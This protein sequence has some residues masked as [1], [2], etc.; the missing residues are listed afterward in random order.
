MGVA[1]ASSR[2]Q[3]G[4]FVIALMAVLDAARGNASVSEGRPGL[5]AA[6][7]RNGNRPGSTAGSTSAPF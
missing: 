1:A 7:L 2:P 4:S 6:W 5:G 3:R